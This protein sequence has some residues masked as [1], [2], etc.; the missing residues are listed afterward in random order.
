MRKYVLFITALL[1]LAQL[2]ACGGTTDTPDTGDTAHEETTEAEE[3]R[4][5]SLPE[6]LNFNDALHDRRPGRG[7]GCNG[8][9]LRGELLHGFPGIFRGRAE[10]K[11]FARERKAARL[12][13]VFLYELK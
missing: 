6:T 3:I 13:F 8:S 9:A 12:S 10:G 5:S 4:L 7:F 2:I 1:I 11:I